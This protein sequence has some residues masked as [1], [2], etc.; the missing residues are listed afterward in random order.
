MGGIG[1]QKG[2]DPRTPALKRKGPK[3]PG[4]A[5]PLAAAGCRGNC[6]RDAQRHRILAC[7]SVLVSSCFFCVLSLENGTTKFLCNFLARDG[8]SRSLRCTVLGGNRDRA[9]R[10]HYTGG[11]RHKLMTCLR[12]TFFRIFPATRRHPFSVPAASAEN[13]T[14]VLLPTLPL[15]TSW[16][17]VIFIATTC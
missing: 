11:L 15:G 8:L 6:W 17:T 2:G 4:V 14:C 9:G 12:S 16:S 3:D 13:I 10:E 1:A 5:A 7:V